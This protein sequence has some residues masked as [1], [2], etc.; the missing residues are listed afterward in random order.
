[1]SSSSTSNDKTKKSGGGRPTIRTLADLN[2]QAASSSDGSDDSDAPQEYYTGGEKS[3]M[4]VQDPTKGNGAGAGPDIEGFFEQVRQMG[5]MPGRYDPPNPSSSTSRSFTGTARTLSGDAPPPPPAPVP[6]A[7]QQ[8]HSILHNIVFWSNGF[9]V[10]DGPL[11]SFE[12]PDNAPFLES[13]K[14][15]ECPRE[16][17]PA[18]RR[19]VVNV[20]L[21]RRAEDYRAPV[22]P[23]KPFQGVG[24][25]LGEGSSFDIPA[26]A[27]ARTSSSSSGPSTGSALVGLSVDDSL[28]STTIQ[29]RLADGTRMVAR[30][31]TSHTVGH[32]R[33]FVEASRLG[34]AT[35]YQLHTG[36]PPKVLSDSSLTIEQAGL[37]NSV[38]IQKM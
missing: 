23:P 32:I 30:F 13:I 5:A 31:N 21:V 29:L 28:P 24:R 2:R 11:R 7:P 27:E 9:T 3:G 16:L 17:E 4:L 34:M 26:A 19:T 25:T 20:N 33:A 12:D 37:A 14:R 6:P 15:S 8:P 38:V 18:D 36:F 10:D 35:S 22:A 1:M